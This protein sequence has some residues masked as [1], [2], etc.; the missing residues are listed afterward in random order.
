MM[1]R[2][3]TQG[4]LPDTGTGAF[5]AIPCMRIASIILLLLPIAACS[6][7]A[8]PP[9]RI[10]PVIAVPAE[11]KDVPLQI[12]AIGNVEA[13]N[14]VAVKSQVNGEIAEV[15]FREGQDVR[16]GERLFLIDPRP[17][18][19]ALRQAESALAR[20]QAQAKN[21]RE[22]ATRYASLVEK[23]FVARQ[24]YDSVQT[25]ADA[26]DA[27]V[28][29]DE[30]AVENA[31]LQLGYTRIL[32][33]IDGRTGAIQIKKG[34]VVKAN[35]LAI[36][37]I[38]QIA[39]INVSFAVPEQELPAIKR[40]RTTG[41]LAVEARIPQNGP[42]P[43]KGKLTFID[44]AVNTAT[45]TILLKA[46]F[47]NAD[48]ALWPGQFVDVVL[49]LT[50]ERRRLLVPGQAV[51]TGQQGQY[52]FVI[53][54]DM[55]A[56]MRPIIPLRTYENWAV[57]AGGVKPGELVVTDGQLRLVPGV[58]VTIKNAEKAQQNDIGKGNGE[59]GPEQGKADA[60]EKEG[61]LKARP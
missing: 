48:H 46:T 40:Y 20:D 39:P 12:K 54:D 17:F 31:R 5:H 28:K 32:S 60:K 51:Q 2:S 14:T 56:D 19:A 42:K 35:D 59:G 7:D 37:T 53:K 41:E 3:K 30:A 52:V 4:S 23:G 43:V 9:P 57:L 24:E 21:A 50:T 25:N 11:Q 18:E 61:P 22:Q 58:K 16:Q 44:N 1:I 49:T 38:N 13:L 33:P 29:A 47:P 8:P 36:V 10:V 45:G 34:N 27:V 6:K 55:T 15:Y 26:L